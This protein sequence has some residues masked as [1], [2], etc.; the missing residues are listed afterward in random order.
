MRARDPRAGT[1]DVETR[2]AVTGHRVFD[3][4]A[5]EHIRSGVEQLLEMLAATGPVRVITNL[6]E[7]ADQLVVE[8]AVQR[9]L[10][11]E[12]IVPAAGFAESLP[13]P[14][15]HRYAELLT[16]ADA[17]RTLDYPAPSPAAYREAGLAMLAGADLLLA[18]W[19]GFPARGVGGSA[20]VVARARELDLPVEVIWP[21]GYAR[22]A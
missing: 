13:E 11:L 22:P 19:D 2:V 5:A 7:G 1:P 17:V 18:V 12:V 4:A 16:A 6:A 3:A 20:E 15:Q 10:Q 9:G 8:A 21:P 14:D